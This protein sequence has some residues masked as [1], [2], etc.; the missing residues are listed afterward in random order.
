MTTETIVTPAPAVFL[1]NKP[2][3]KRIELEWPFLYDGATYDHVIVRR[4][5]TGQVAEFISNASKS[6]SSFSHFPMYFD[7]KG[8]SLTDDILKMFDEDDYATCSE[9]AL[10]FLPRRFQGMKPTAPTQEIGDSTQ[11]A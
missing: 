9:V 8:A 7:E 11:L 1:G 2:R 3:E 10:D 4:M 5:T 6:Q